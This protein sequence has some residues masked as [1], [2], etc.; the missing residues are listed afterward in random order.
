MRNTRE[1]SVELSSLSELPSAY[2]QAIEKY[3]QLMSYTLYSKDIP[4]AY[5]KLKEIHFTDTDRVKSY[6]CVF[7][8]ED[9]FN[10]KE[11]RGE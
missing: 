6:T 4:N 7:I 11:Y 3:K 9:T 1:I 8:L 10:L 5:I 2:E